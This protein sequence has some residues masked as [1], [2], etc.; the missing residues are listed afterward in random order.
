MNS[1][2]I[3][4]FQCTPESEIGM[5]RNKKFK[6]NKQSTILPHTPIILEV[7][8]AALMVYI[9]FPAENYRIKSSMVTKTEWAGA[10]MNI[11]CKYIHKESVD[12]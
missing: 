12:F 11:N 6:V 1:H 8:V 3:S 7:L 2:I 4:C 9:C 10:G 5:C